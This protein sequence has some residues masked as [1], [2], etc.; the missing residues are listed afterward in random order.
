MPRGHLDRVNDIR[1]AIADIRSDTAG[2][3]F[4]TFEGNLVVVRAVLYSVG[5]IG[6]AVKALAPELKAAHPD[7]P[8]RAIAGI[9]DRV[10]HE[11]FRMNARRIW[12]VVQ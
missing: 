5:V 3:T 8:W 11:Y 2:M 1:S 10:V 4:K 6:E 12:D 9:R 7:I